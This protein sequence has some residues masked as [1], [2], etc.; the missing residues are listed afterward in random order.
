[1]LL[2]FLNLSDKSDIFQPL[3]CSSFDCMADEIKIIGC[4]CAILLF[5]MGPVWHQSLTLGF[6]S[7]CLRETFK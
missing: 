3:E 7:S 5:G 6:N 4:V 1:M 2:I